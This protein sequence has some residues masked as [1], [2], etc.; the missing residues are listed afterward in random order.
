MRYW[1]NGHMDSGWGVLMIFGVLGIWALVAVG[2]VW[3]VRMTRTP[4]VPFGSP[5][6][7]LTSA[8]VTASAQQVLAERLAHGEIDPDEYA[9]RLAVLR[10]QARS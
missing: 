5:P 7:S 8:S 9:A 3:I 1:D 2:T 6:S 4:Q 10:S